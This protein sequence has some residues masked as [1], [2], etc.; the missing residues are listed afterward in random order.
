MTIWA[1]VLAVALYPA[2][3][4]LRLRLGGRGGLAATLITVLGLLIVL[5]PLGAATLSLTDTTADLVVRFQEHTINVPRPPDSVKEWP[6]IGEKVHAAWTLASVNLEAAAKRFGPQFMAA[7]G[8]IA[9]KVA[10]IGLGMIGFAVSVLISGLLFVPGQRLAESVKAF[11]RR[12]SPDRGA[13]FTDLAGAT[14]H[15][16][17]YN[18][19]EL[20]R[21]MRAA[22]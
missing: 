11:A 20:N 19:S 8:N 10:G 13:E 15:P 18:R 7:S 2:F 22:C 3:E 1:V 9:A 12:V 4:A 6:F 5:G 17:G 21:Q 16:K 14:I